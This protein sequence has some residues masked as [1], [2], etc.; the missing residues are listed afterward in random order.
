MQIFDEHFYTAVLIIF[1]M[2]SPL[3][4]NRILICF[5]KGYFIRKNLNQKRLPDT[6]KYYVE[7]CIYENNT[8]TQIRLRNGCLTDSYNPNTNILYL[9]EATY[10]SSSPVA[11]AIALHEFG[12]IM[13]A[14]ENYIWHIISWVVYRYISAIALIAVV[15]F[16]LGLV[17][18][19]SFLMTACGIL[20][21]IYILIAFANIKTEIDASNRAKEQLKK[22]N[23]SE[24]D[25][26]SCCKLLKVA[27]WTYITNMIGTLSAA[28]IL[29]KATANQYKS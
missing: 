23:L 25:Y 6:A 4:L 2:L 10:Y 19:S 16:L 24:E 3:I 15:G 21:L 9:A 20:I 13:Q 29:A 5:L 28:I 18:N 12:H 26:N 14:K 11:V 27:Y 1:L 7:T 8:T 17:L 22:F